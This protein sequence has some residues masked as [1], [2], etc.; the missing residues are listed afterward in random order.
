MR[1]REDE[2][3]QAVR[4]AVRKISRADID[5]DLTEVM[6]KRLQMIKETVEFV[7]KD[8]SAT[9]LRTAIVETFEEIESERNSLEPIARF[10]EQSLERAAVE[11]G[12]RRNS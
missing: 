8:L 11:S 12:D 10:C 6:V 1:S 2:I 3:K 7:V 9:E 5:G 4:F